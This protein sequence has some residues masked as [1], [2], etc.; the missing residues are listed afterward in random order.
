[1]ALS[2][3]SVAIRNSNGEYSGALLLLAPLTAKSAA[4][5]LS[6]GGA[7]VLQPATLNPTISNGGQIKVNNLFLRIATSK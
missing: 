1:L 5:M 3:L 7:T 6:F 4:A 2:S